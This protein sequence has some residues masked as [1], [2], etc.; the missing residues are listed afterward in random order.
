MTAR[1]RKPADL[2]DAAAAFAAEALETLAGLMRASG[3][4]QVKVAAARELLD[5]A[6]GKPKA[7][8]A[9]S[10]GATLEELIDRANLL[11]KE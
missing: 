2:K 5:R 4:D 9:R 7:E 1:K 8:D 10:Q 3:S 6:H 11:E